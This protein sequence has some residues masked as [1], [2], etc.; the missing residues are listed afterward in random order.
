MRLLCAAAVSLALGM[1]VACA[2]DKKPADPKERADKLAA[3]KKKFETEYAALEKRVLKAETPADARVKTEFCEL[4]ALTAEKA[5]T[6]AKDDPKDDTGFAAAEFIVQS[7]SK[8]GGGGKDV[9]EAVGLI[10]EHHAGSAKVKELLLPAMRLGDGGDKLLKAVCEKG[11]DKDAKAVAFFLRGYKISQTL[12]DE[13]DEDKLT[14]KVAEATLLIEK[15]VNESPEAKLGRT[16][17]GE[18]AKKELENLKGVTAVAVGKPRGCRDDAPRREEGQA[19]DYKGKVVLLDIWATWCPPCRDDSA[20][21][22]M[23]KNMK[24]MPFV[25]ISAAPTTRRT[26]S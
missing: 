6:I 25:L 1:F 7:A 19:S 2:E 15:S 10:A 20:R 17:V 11:P 8:A 4:V 3:I 9:E 22:E 14:A 16:T 18:G 12:D 5:L 23:A 26:R 24:D 13:E 21:C